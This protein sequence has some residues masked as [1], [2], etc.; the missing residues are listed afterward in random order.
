MI[1]N[2]YTLHLML[3]MV[4]EM[5]RHVMVEITGYV[6]VMRT[7][8]FVYVSHQEQGNI[9]VDSEL[10]MSGEWRLYVF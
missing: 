7:L 5:S 8:H 4:L 3:E 9:L 6:M 2:Y 10:E 1:F